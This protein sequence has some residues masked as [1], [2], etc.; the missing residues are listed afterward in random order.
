MINIVEFLGLFLG[1]FVV[2]I[3][4]YSL[5]IK[6]SGIDFKNYKILSI[7]L[8]S[9][10]LIPG[11]TFINLFFLNKTNKN[12]T[13]KC[14]ISNMRVFFHIFYIFFT[15]SLPGLLLLYFTNISSIFSNSL[16]FNTDIFNERK[17]DTDHLYA[18]YKDPI[19]LI[20]EFEDNDTM[21]I[22][23][24]NQKLIGLIGLKIE[25]DEYNKIR[26]IIMKKELIGYFIWL[27]FIGSVSLIISYNS[28]LLECINL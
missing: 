8:F 11:N 20:Q 15:V 14:N 16:Y 12:N 4:I 25:V 7:C 1:L 19:L 21:S 9:F 2:F 17:N 18:F 10:F 28:I 5:L 13:N 27:F 22:E 24:F 26:D 23:D 6:S 3:C